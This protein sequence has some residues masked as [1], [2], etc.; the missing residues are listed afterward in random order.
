MSPTHNCHNNL[1]SAY[2]SSHHDISNRYNWLTYYG[3]FT[4]ILSCIMNVFIMAFQTVITG[5]LVLTLIALKS[6]IC[7]RLWGLFFNRDPCRNLYMVRIHMLVKLLLGFRLVI[8]LFTSEVFLVIFKPKSLKFLTNV[9]GF[10]T[11]DSTDVGRWFLFETQ[12][13]APP[14]SETRLVIIVV[15]RSRI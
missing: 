2:A 15:K 8:T 12:F 1:S 9:R 11:P 13:G 6:V 3:I 10:S 5:W 7:C 14:N 4:F